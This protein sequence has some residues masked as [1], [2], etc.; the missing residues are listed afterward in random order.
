MRR[1]WCRAI[2]VVLTVLW[3][4]A[5]A[6]TGGTGAPKPLPEAIA[7]AWKDAGAK[8]GWMQPDEYGVG[9]F[10]PKSSGKEG[11]LPGL[12]VPKLNLKPGLL[13]ALPDPGVAFG[14]RLNFS[15]ITDAGLKELAGLKSLRALF[16]HSTGVTGPGLKELAALPDLRQ[17]ELSYNPQVTGVGLKE[18]AAL[19]GLRRLQLRSTSTSDAGLKEVAELKGLRMLNL[20][21]TKVTDAGLGHLAALPRLEWPDLSGNVQRNSGFTDAGLK[22]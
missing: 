3:L 18:L 8:V 15:G 7:T 14:L 19:K 11:E 12:L 17:L 21:F 20:S 10:Y 1:T 4:P 2:G 5:A 22:D 13:A 16:L 9:Y 6:D